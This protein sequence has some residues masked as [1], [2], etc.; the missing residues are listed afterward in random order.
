MLS[1]LLVR[2]VLVLAVTAARSFAVLVLVGG[3]V[4]GGGPGAFRWVVHGWDGR[5]AERAGGEDRRVRSTS[6]RVTQLMQSGIQDQLWI[7]ALIHHLHEQPTRDGAES[8]LYLRVTCDWTIRDGRRGE[9]RFE[10]SSICAQ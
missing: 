7:E 9:L 10:K 8:G 3:R 2:P 6:T 4:L 5:W 1:I